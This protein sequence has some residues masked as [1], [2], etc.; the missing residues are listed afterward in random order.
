M[1]NKFFMAGKS[2]LLL[3]FVMSMIG[4]SADPKGLAKQ[5]YDLGQEAL[6]ALLN[7]AKAAEVQKKAEDISKKVTKLSA[8]DRAVYEQELVRLGG[9]GLG[10]LF[11]AASTLDA[12]SVQDA[13][14][15]AGQAVDTAQQAVDFLNTL[16]GGR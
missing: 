7:P 10:A 1:K 3:I 6:G 14:N 12:A 4:C 2:V 5:T 16:G 11:D 9:Q 8:N 15:T 13:L